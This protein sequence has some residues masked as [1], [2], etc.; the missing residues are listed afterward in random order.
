MECVYKKWWLVVREA[1]A[2]GRGTR[3][4]CPLCRVLR[5]AARKFAIIPTV[6]IRRKTGNHLERNGTTQRHVVLV[7]FLACFADF[8]P[9]SRFLS[10]IPV[11]SA[12]HAAGAF[13]SRRR[14]GKLER[15]RRVW[16]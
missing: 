12:E 2:V 5:N 14:C 3:P 8:V 16:K 6:V 4:A 11:A 7:R 1:T 10:G 15:K 13:L 9:A